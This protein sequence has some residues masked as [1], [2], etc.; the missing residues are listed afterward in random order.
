MTGVTLQGSNIP[1]TQPTTDCAK[2]K[3]KGNIFPQLVADD[4]FLLNQCNTLICD[5]RNAHVSSSARPG[6]REIRSF[7]WVTDILLSLRCRGYTR[8]QVHCQETRKQKLI[9]KKEKKKK[10][11]MKQ[12]R[13]PIG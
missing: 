6:L 9:G 7:V 1:E 4:A 5:K 8:M 12:S 2:K 13:A 11:K 10:R 3:K